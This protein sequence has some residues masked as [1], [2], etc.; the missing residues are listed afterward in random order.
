MSTKMQR[1][2]IYDF[3]G[4]LL[5][6]IIQKN[7]DGVK[8]QPRITLCGESEDGERRRVS[9]LTREVFKKEHEKYSRP[10]EKEYVKGARRRSAFQTKK[11]K[12]HFEVPSTNFIRQAEAAANH[13][14]AVHAQLEMIGASKVAHDEYV[15]E[16]NKGELPGI[17]DWLGRVVEETEVELRSSES[18]RM[19]ALK[20]Y[21]K[22]DAEMSK[23]PTLVDVD[24]REIE[25]RTLAY[26]QRESRLHRKHQT[27]RIVKYVYE[28]PAPKPV[29]EKEPSVVRAFANPV[30][31][32]FNDNPQVLAIGDAKPIGNGSKKKEISM[33]RFFK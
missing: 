18:G 31:D 21:C 25:F 8:E 5:G 14:K 2:N 30:A 23:C 27:P 12:K 6:F 32:R 22:K 3:D 19:T 33:K 1:K 20:Q 9:L 28:P 13:L 7:S 11:E 4:K 17:Q 29:K 26:M 16:A 10:N 24:F 15:L